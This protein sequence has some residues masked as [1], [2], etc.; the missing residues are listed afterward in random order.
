ME[1]SAEEMFAKLGYKKYIHKNMDGNVIE[2]GYSDQKKVFPKIIS[3]DLLDGYLEAENG[4]YY[5]KEELQAI[6][7]Q[8]NELGWLD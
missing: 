2:I 4:D 6:N 1:L 7:K 3:F 8:L 5:S